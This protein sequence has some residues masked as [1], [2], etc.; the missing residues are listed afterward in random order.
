MWSQEFFFKL[1]NK[2]PAGGFGTPKAP[3][4]ARQASVLLGA[5]YP[6]AEEKR[7]SEDEEFAQWKKKYDSSKKSATRT[8]GF[9]P[10]ACS[11]TLV[12]LPKR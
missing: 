1:G 11:V 5:A 10:H 12:T 9:T 8:S 7:A 2:N 4:N 3:F 6:E